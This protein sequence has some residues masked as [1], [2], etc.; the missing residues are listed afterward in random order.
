MPSGLRAPGKPPTTVLPTSS[1]SASTNSTDARVLVPSPAEAVTAQRYGPMS[2]TSS[3]SGPSGVPSDMTGTIAA[4]SAQGSDAVMSRAGAVPPAA[5]SG[6]SA[7]CGAIAVAYS[8]ATSHGA[9]SGARWYTDSSMPHG[10][11]PSW[12]S[13][14][15]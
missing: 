13:P 5:R 14:I 2:P 12:G 11:S 10:S 15:G 6:G 4:A 8:R 7:S 3:A 9:L 1:A